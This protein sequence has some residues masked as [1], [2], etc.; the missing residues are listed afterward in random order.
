MPSFG[1]V[2]FNIMHQHIFVGKH[3]LA[4][5]GYPNSRGFLAPYRGVR[6]HP[7][8]YSTNPL[9]T[10]QELFNLRHSKLRNVVE[11]RFVVLKSQFH[12][13]R[14][15]SHY[16]LRTQSKMVVPT[17]VLHNFICKWNG[18]D[19]LFENHMNEKLDC[20]E[21]EGQEN[22]EEIHGTP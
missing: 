8:K 13:I 14:T 19:E 18:V 6:Y 21:D 7:K 20:E 1:D 9:T 5:A 4:D 16:P 3:L 22:E 15:V 2:F 11:S 12:I 10:A 17:C